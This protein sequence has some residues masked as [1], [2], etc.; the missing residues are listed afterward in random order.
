MT[1][2]AILD[3]Q[4]ALRAGLTMLLRGEPGLV[5]VGSAA[6]AGE[7]QTLVERLHPDVML[8]EYA[9]PGG[10]GLHICRRLKALAK[11]PSVILYTA[12]RDPGVHVGA[13]VAGADGLVDKAAPPGQLFDAIRT[14]SRGG[15]VLPTVTRAQLDEAAHRIDP[16]DLPLL[17]L[18]VDR[19]SIAETADTLRLDRRKVA[20]RVERMLGRLRTGRPAGIAA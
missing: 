14:V 12:E 3:P 15:T 6:T 7:A 17:A 4:P 20:R 18:L 19:T 11:P 1:R 5:P 9:L 8:I 13:R 16:D 2:V 10:D